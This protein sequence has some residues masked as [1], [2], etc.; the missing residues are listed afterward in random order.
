MRTLEW[1][2][3]SRVPTRGVVCDISVLLKLCEEP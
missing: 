1:A 3:E 2:V